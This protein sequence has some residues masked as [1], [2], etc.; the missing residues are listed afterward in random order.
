MGRIAGR[1]AK[2]RQRIKYL[3]SLLKDISVEDTV[4]N[5]IRMP[6]ER[7]EWR[8]MIPNVKRDMALQ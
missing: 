3:D 5:L 6:E 2:G 1:R 7:E 8:I 4:T